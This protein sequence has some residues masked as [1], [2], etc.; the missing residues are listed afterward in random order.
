ME[1]RKLSVSGMS[2]AGCARAVE[3]ALLSVPGV[4]SA[5][6]NV[7]AGAAAVRWDPAK[8]KEA[9]LFEAVRRAGYRPAPY[10]EE[11]GG[12]FLRER[13][14]LF[15]AAAVAL[16]ILLIHQEMAAVPYA[17]FALLALATL[18]QFT[19]GLRFYRGAFRSLRS[20]NAGMDVLV[21][22]G[23][24]AAW[25]Y[26][27]AVV[28]FP[29]FLA[30]A[31]TFFHTA[32]M[33]I[34]FIRFGKM[35]E[36]SAKGR[37]GDAMRALMRSRPERALRLTDGKEESVP[38]SEVQVGDLLRVRPGDSVPVDSEVAE[39]EA[40]VDEAS[41][42]GESIP[43]PRGPGDRVYGGTIV[44]DGVL[45]LRAAAVGE[46]TFLARMVRMVE[47]AQ[48]DRAPI[49][50]FADRV[51]NR[52]V[53]V[54]VAVALLAFL[55]WLFVLGQAF[56]F[57]L[58]RAVAV[59]V[60]A[61]PCALGLATP[62]AILVGSGIGLGRGILFKRG[63]ALE[64]IA[65]VG[66]VLFDKT[67]T[68][69]EGR[70]V[71][72]DWAAMV[73]GK[74]EELLAVAAAGAAL[75]NH[76]LSR[77]LLHAAE[78]RGLTIHEAKQQ[79]EL[80]GK[81]IRFVLDGKKCLLG[82]DALLEEEN[83]SREELAETADRWALEGKTVLWLVMDGTAMAVFA[84]RDEPKEGAANAVAR[85][86]ALGIRTALLTGDRRATA[87]GIAQH[88][89]FGDVFAEVPP[90]KKAEIVEKVRGEGMVV[91]M[92]GDGIND[93]PALARAD[94][95]VA[96]GAG[97][98]V[99]K[100]TGDVVLVQSDPRDVAS[101]IELGRA[102]LRK[103]KQNLFWALVYN[104]IA[105]PFAAGLFARWNLLLPPEI[106]ALAMALSSVAV[107]MNSLDLRRWRP[108]AA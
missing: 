63:S 101:A 18:L 49:Q 79:M 45:V 3:K 16:P 35:L 31:E 50:R 37:A 67:G 12:D 19:A 23:I 99:A 102:T 11:E 93:A 34:L 92:V 83:V 29:R 8:A 108:V 61:C 62:T 32:A 25:A 60:V 4:E 78:E 26:S 22:T 14:E 86:E 42:T 5:V 54:V 68:V 44:R 21:A 80:P 65:R 38:I 40:A 95:G 81:G 77:A 10:G 6:V 55:V 70:P 91:A 48:L 107:V 53:P 82:G 87:D 56:S 7:A 27:A 94:V 85:I 15:L 52:F 75:S 46:A 39:G 13:I 24:T 57:A 76:P 9:D 17:P 41:L 43:V 66:F 71:M 51:S 28:L 98:D 73:Q 72:T 30:G 106:A 36:A 89:G 20:G 90:D 96:I 69:T 59:L 105:I 100:E 104:V 58:S 74:E 33:L 103:I 88:T 47:E 1:Q 84:L 97:T 2:C 64:R